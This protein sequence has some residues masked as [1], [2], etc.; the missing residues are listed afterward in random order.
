MKTDV[1]DRRVHLLQAQVNLVAAAS[2]GY[3]V[4]N[5]RS[6]VA[7]VA[8]W[9]AMVLNGC[10][11]LTAGLSVCCLDLMAHTVGAALA[12]ETLL[13]A[14][15]VVAASACCSYPGRGGRGGD[16]REVPLA[17]EEKRS[18]EQVSLTADTA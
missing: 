11:M 9:A 16:G 17:D 3:S 14:A 13:V 8:G 5:P 18:Y 4:C 10:W 12:L 2:F 15:V 6:M 1:S 7:Y